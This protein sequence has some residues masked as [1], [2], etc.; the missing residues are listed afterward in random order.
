M[1]L[2]PKLD[3]MSKKFETKNTSVETEKFNKAVEFFFGM[4]PANRYW[5]LLALY[6]AK[7]NNLYAI[8]N[9]D[10]KNEGFVMA[11]MSIDHIGNTKIANEW[12]KNNIRNR[13][14]VAFVANDQKNIIDK[15]YCSL[16]IDAINDFNTK[17]NHVLGLE[18]LRQMEP[19]ILVEVAETLINLS[20]TWY[21]DNSQWAFD[22]LLRR[23]MRSDDRI[24]GMFYQ[25]KELTQLMVSLLDAHGG[26][27]YNPYAG[28]CAFGATLD[29]DCTYYGQELSISYIIGML[30]LLF[31]GKKNS[32]CEQGDSLH[33]W[34]INEKFD[35][36]ISV[37]PF[38]VRCDNVY[39]MVEKD[40]LYRS[41]QYAQHKAI[42]LYP[43]SVCFEKGY[44][45]TATPFLKDLVQKDYIEGVV[46]L[47]TNIFPATSVETVIIVVNKQKPRK[48]EIRFVDASGLFVKS[49][50]VNKLYSESIL[51]LYNSDCEKS[52]SVPVSVIEEN[53]YKIYPKYYL[54]KDLE[55]PEGMQAISLYDVLTPMRMQYPNSDK[56]RVLTFSAKGAFSAND[57]IK[58][59]DLEVRELNTPNFRYVN[60][61]CLIINRGGRFSA[62]YLMTC[63]ENVYM[64]QNYR[65]FLVDLGRI[66]PIYLLSELSKDYFS[67]Q[68]AR[69]GS[70][71]T[72]P[73]I[74]VEEFLNLMILIPSVRDKQVSMSLDSIEKNI[75]ALE[76]KIDV[77]YKN[78][79]E[80]FILNQRQRKHAVA[81]VLN[82]IVPSV[83]NVE[84]YIWEHETV[85]KDSIV[86]RRFGTT[87]KQY[88]ASIR[89]QLDKVAIMVDNFTNLEQ[90]GEPECIG[91]EDFLTGYSNSK[92]ALNI[93]VVYNHNH[94][95]E[96]IKQEVKI[97]K[98][99]LTQMLD[100]LVSNAVKYGAGRDSIQMYGN[101]KEGR[102]DFLIRIETFAVHDYKDPVIIKVSN[103]GELVSKSIS[104][105][106]LFTWGIGQGTGIGC[107]QV[108]EIAEHFGGS[109]SYQEFPEDQEGFACEFSIVLPLNE[110]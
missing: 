15:I 4:N 80:S 25:P 54:G 109:A 41:S 76:N 62:R 23:A 29:T 68:V 57:T 37:P 17:G 87:L 50:K 39:R 78:K 83:E 44:S 16:N 90:F 101:S 43:S 22:L 91:L 46:L 104:L 60:E 14:I 97:S 32:V 48:N 40:Y 31:N 5:I 26:K 72:G 3:C 86:S 20:D 74:S 27:V 69:F 52:K 92:K 75:E 6:F 105:E 107:W 9:Y 95:D 28:S 42:G 34:N 61:D 2:Y 82:E 10:D 49:G 47:P 55:V 38:G 45:L 70:G 58:A 21:E 71:V 96:E 67:E 110:D 51:S 53:G 63:G 1:K 98:K 36:I 102:K 19:T 64:R 99:D 18:R 66:D 88:L 11:S 65:P 24:N 7:T 77:E 93:N 100:N 8:D 94:E 81:Q 12:A 103:N 84:S 30:N 108:K 59:S 89:Q 35:Y 79:L 73:R 56:G 85:G 106:K 33:N 13:S